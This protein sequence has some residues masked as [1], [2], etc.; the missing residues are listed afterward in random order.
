M[1]RTGVFLDIEK[2]KINL[3]TAKIQ[4]SELQLFFAAGK[5]LRVKKGQDLTEVAHLMS[6]DDSNK[7][8]EMIK[9]NV[10]AAVSDKEAEDWFSDD[11]LLWSVVVKPYVLVQVI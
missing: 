8:E 3:E 7:I 9:A 1:V 2:A 6:L 4:W 5:V 11:A 10:L